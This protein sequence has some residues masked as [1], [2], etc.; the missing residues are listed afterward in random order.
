M[1]YSVG[2]SHHANLRIYRGSTDTLLTQ[3]QQAM[4]ELDPGT[5][6]YQLL[7][8]STFYVKD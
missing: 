7:D 8:N 3:T 6:V 2:L 4:Q 5:V 1:G